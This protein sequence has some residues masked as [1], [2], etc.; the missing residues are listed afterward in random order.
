M[1]EDRDELRA[2]DVDR[3]FVAER[4]REALN[5]GRLDLTEY[6]DRLGQ[7]YSA[8]TYGDLK[9]LLSDLPTVAPEAKSQLQPAAQA[10]VEP[11]VP[12]NLTGQ[13]LAHEWR[14]WVSISAILTV[15]WLAS[16]RGY[17][18]PVW[19]I[20]IL[21]AL[22]LVQSVNGLATGEPRKR[23]ERQRRKEVERQARRERQQEERQR[24]QAADQG[25]QQDRQAADQARDQDDDDVQGFQVRF[26]GSE[27]R[28][29]QELRRQADHLERAHRQQEEQFERMRR[30]QEEHFERARRRRDDR[31]RHRHD[32]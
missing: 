27:D 26:R 6:D 14:D 29:E 31:R 12:K 20:G 25:D 16:G 13:W 7:A 17:F 5:E 19:V 3:E 2:A 4:L 23:W 8:R 24:R 9:K 32:F 30:R 21:G 1:S 15:I 11:A 18:W 28:Y 22:K 10:P